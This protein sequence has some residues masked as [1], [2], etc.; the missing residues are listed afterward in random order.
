MKL[1]IALQ[2]HNYQRRLCW[3]LSSF[4]QQDGDIPEITVNIASLKN[5]GSPSTEEVIECFRDNHLNIKHT[6]IIDY[7]LRD[8]IHYKHNTNY[9]RQY[10]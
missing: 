1:E 7:R 4:L 10:Y 3:Q 9:T 8:K 6:V 2:C 5:N